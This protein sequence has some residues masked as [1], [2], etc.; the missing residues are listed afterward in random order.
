MALIKL[1]DAVFV[2]K[3]PTNIGVIKAADGSAVVIDTGIDES[4]ARKLLRELEHEGLQIKA[5]INTHAHADHIGGN[6]FIVSRTKAVIYA[7]EAETALLENPL[8]E[9]SMLIGGAYPWKEMRNKFLLAKPSTVSEKLTDGTVTINNI[10]LEIIPLAGHSLGHIGVLYDG[11]LF[12]GDA[13]ISAIALEK[14]SIPYNVDIPTYLSSLEKLANIQCQ[15][16]VPSHG[17][18]AQDISCD[19]ENNRT[20]VLKQIQ[21]LEDWLHEPQTAEELLVK[22]CSHLGTS[23]ANPSLFF[24]YRTAVL[25][26]LSYLYETN[27]AKTTLQDNRLLWLK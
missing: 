1:T 8:L 23:A 2:L 3:A 16:F 24:L 25:A 21:L 12:T 13:Y 4:V 15:W 17:D 19:L 18:P 10:P 6:S 22:L 20:T 9:P 7:S 26:Y 5:I 11:V 27:R 14:Y